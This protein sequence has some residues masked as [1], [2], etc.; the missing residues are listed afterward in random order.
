MT[1]DPKLPRDLKSG[2][3]VIVD[4]VPFEILSEPFLGMT[5]ASP[6]D[7]PALFWRALMRPLAGDREV[8]SYAT[9]AVDETDAVAMA[10]DT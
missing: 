5:G 4:G 10:G 9:W 3:V 1:R 7:T 6:F 2:D 8:P